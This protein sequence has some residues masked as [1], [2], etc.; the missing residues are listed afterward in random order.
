V[1]I[2]LFGATETA[3]TDNMISASLLAGIR[4]NV[5]ATGNLVWRNT[6]T[7]NPA[8]IEFVITPTGSSSGNWLLANR[9]ATNTCGIKGP[10][11]NNTISGNTFNGNG[12]DSCQ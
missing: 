3:V 2:L 1:G 4:F 9:I 7:A 10:V 6:V 8:G 5:L 12:T 11:E